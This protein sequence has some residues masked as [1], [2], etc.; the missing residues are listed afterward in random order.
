MK[1][2]FKWFGYLTIASFASFLI[3]AIVFTSCDFDY[4]TPQ[5][6]CEYYVQKILENSEF[7]SNM[8]VSKNDSIVKLY[9]D[10]LNT[11]F[12]SMNLE[13]GIVLWDDYLEMN[14]TLKTCFHSNICQTQND[15]NSKILSEIPKSYNS[16]IWGLNCKRYIEDILAQQ[17]FDSEKMQWKT[18]G[19]RRFRVYE[20]TYLVD[21]KITYENLF[22]GS[23]TNT[24]RV[25]VD[26][27]GNVQGYILL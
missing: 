16:H 26:R 6:K 25:S 24:V 4:K 22:G 10:S 8:L 18:L 11:T 21:G 15:F 19:I 27:H 12:H 20:S 5:D 23:V 1:K 7:K 3:M 9:A 13:D 14:D 17:H 2:I